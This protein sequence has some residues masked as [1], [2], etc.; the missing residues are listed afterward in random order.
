MGIGF[1]LSAVD[2][3]FIQIVHANIAGCVKYFVPS[4][5]NTDMN[6]STF[7]I[8]KKSKISR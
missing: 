7:G 3:L 4:A 6:D 1:Q 2:A 8:G 5:N